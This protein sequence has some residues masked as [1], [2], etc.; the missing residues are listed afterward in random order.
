MDLGSCREVIADGRTGFLVHNVQEAAAAVQ[1]TKEIKRR[2]CRDQVQ[3]RFSIDAMIDGYERVY[4]EI[5]ATGA[6]SIP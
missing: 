1:K 6:K 2:E 5:F 4:E 3:R